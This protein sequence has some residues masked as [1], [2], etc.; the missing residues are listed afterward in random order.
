MDR[1]SCKLTTRR[2]EPVAVSLSAKDIAF[3]FVQ[4]GYVQSGKVECS[5][6]HR[7]F[8]LLFDKRDVGSHGKRHSAK[9]S[10]AFRYFRE[11]VTRDHQDGHPL[12]HL[13]KD[14]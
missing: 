6:C 7:A 14:I 3:S 11:R 1:V 4:Q 8:V 10:Q 5:V 12:E 2:L 13:S 9:Y